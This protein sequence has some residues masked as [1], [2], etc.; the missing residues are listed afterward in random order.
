[1]SEVTL[2]LGDCLELMKSIPDKS[3]DAVITDPPYGIGENNEKNASRVN[4]ATPKDYGHYEWDKEKA[5]KEQIDAIFR[6]SK[7]QIIF[8]GNYYELP[9][10][11]CW[12]VWD[13]MNGNND[14]ADC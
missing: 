2:L 13:K 5:S 12:I 3:M 6:I 7:N 14:F 10:T 4:L 8:G 1:M 9:P 11:P